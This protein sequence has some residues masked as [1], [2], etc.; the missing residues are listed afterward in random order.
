MLDHAHARTRW[1]D[2]GCTAFRE[3]AQE[4]Q[5]NRARIILK[6]VVEEWLPTT[7]LFGRKDQFDF[8]MFQDAGHVL[9]RGGIELV[10]ETGYKELGFG[11][12]YISVGVTRLD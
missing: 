1:T 7:G 3:G 5:R 10:A 11:H 6:A 12:N 2:D 9:K 4:V 8:E